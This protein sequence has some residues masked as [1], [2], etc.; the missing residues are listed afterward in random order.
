MD[1][2]YTHTCVCANIELN[3]IIDATSY[4]RLTPK[5]AEK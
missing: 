4:D 3:L 2:A 5:A 1:N